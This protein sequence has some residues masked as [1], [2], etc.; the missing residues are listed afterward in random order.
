MLVGE[1]GSAKVGLLELRLDGSVLV[2]QVVD[3]VAELLAGVVVAPG[4]PAA[5]QS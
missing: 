3:V 1:F 5:F 2:E 4:V